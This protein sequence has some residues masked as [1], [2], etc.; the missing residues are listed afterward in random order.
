[1]V[2]HPDAV[3]VVEQQRPAVAG[4]PVALLAVLIGTIGIASPGL[5]GLRFGNTVLRECDLRQAAEVIEK[6]RASAGRPES[7][8]A[9]ASSM[10]SAPFTK[11]PTRGRRSKRP[12]ID[13][14]PSG[15]AAVIRPSAAGEM[16]N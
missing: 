4:L 7:A 12:E 14:A 13:I 15:T 2:A 5:P 1:M 11:V 8:R 6:F 10:R 9:S 16:V 3:G